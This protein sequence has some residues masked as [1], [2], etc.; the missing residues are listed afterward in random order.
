[1]YTLGLRPGRYLRLISDGNAS[2]ASQLQLLCLVCS[3]AL[4][5]SLRTL[6]RRENSVTYRAARTWHMDCCQVAN[7]QEGFLHLSVWTTG[8]CPCAICTLGAGALGDIA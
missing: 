2:E 1:M 6:F 5:G 4:E 8:A 3:D 7:R